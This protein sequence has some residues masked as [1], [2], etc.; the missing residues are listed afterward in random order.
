MDVFYRPILKNI[1][2]GMVR[3]L[4]NWNYQQVTG[5]LWERGFRYLWNIKGS[6]QAW[7]KRVDNKP[8][9]V[10]VVNFTHRSYP[11]KTLK[12]II[13]Q[14]GIDQDEWIQWGTS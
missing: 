4:R 9:K 10:V 8:E 11:V 13:R 1:L 3:R 14:S 7:V 12:G 5:F 6:H 2:Y